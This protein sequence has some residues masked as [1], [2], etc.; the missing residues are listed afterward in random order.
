MVAL[1]LKKLVGK[2][3]SNLKASLNEKLELLDRQQPLIHFAIEKFFPL[4]DD[5]FAYTCVRLARD[6][7]WAFGLPKFRTL[8]A[9]QTSTD[10]EQQRIPK[11]CREIHCLIFSICFFLA[12]I[13]WSVEISD[14][15]NINRLTSLD[16]FYSISPVMHQQ[17]IHVY[18]V[19]HYV[20][21]NRRT[22]EAATTPPLTWLLEIRYRRYLTTTIFIFR[23][24][25]VKQR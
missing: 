12:G 6:P 24:E 22:N 17:L 11:R 15:T 14:T 10:P 3:H 9:N 25:R 4:G 5:I 2:P 19:P 16:S 7:F 18:F 1:S 8:A 23:D 20:T 21:R 13:A